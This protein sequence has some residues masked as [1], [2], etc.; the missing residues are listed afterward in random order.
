MHVYD[1][2]EVLTRLDA[3]SGCGFNK[4]LCLICLPSVR[5]PGHKFLRIYRAAIPP[6][7]HIMHACESLLTVGNGSTTNC[8]LAD[9]RQ[10]RLACPCRLRH[11][12]LWWISSNRRCFCSNFFYASEA[13]LFRRRGTTPNVGASHASYTR[14]SICGH[15]VL[16]LRNS[17]GFDSTFETKIVFPHFF[18]INLNCVC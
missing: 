1:Y 4:F 11:F 17:W 14:Q 9:V 2:I 12:A 7:T 13:D 3:F 8:A 16:L 18:Y 5:A 15:S 6:A 10:Q